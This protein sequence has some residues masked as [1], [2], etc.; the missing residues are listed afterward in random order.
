M[1]FESEFRRPL[2][3]DYLSFCVIFCACNTGECLQLHTNVL[4]GDVRGDSNKPQQEACRAPWGDI[5]KL[6]I[7]YITASHSHLYLP[8]EL[9]TKLSAERVDLT[10]AG[11][12]RESAE[13]VHFTPLKGL[14]R[15]RDELISR[16][17]GFVPN[18]GGR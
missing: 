16:G 6:F 15:G 17:C 5:S 4:L 12:V 18:R 7:H 2:Q 8:L 11:Q 1:R 14:N 13:P 3:L 10:R 9:T